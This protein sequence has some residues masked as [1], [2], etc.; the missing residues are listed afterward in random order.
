MTPRTLLLILF[1]VFS[2]TTS[3]AKKEP[4][5]ESAIPASARRVEV[6]VFLMNIYDL[7]PASNSFYADFYLWARWQGED[8][9]PLR[10]LSFSNLVEKGSYSITPA[11]GEPAVSEDGVRYMNWRVE[12]RFFNSFKVDQFP[13][14]RQT[15]ALQLENDE[16]TLDQ[17]VYVPMPAESGLSDE[18][19][20]TGWNVDR[21]ETAMTSN[22]YNTTFGLGA[23]D[24][25]AYSNTSFAVVISRPFNFFVWKLAFPLLIVLISSVAFVFFTVDDFGSRF[26]LPVYALLTAIFLQMA[27]TS[28]IPETGY[29]VLMD[30]I[31]VAAYGLI[32]LNMAQIIWTSWMCAKEKLDVARLTRIDRSLAAGSFAAFVGYGAWLVTAA[33]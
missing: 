26:Y 23:G 1:C 20:L 4:L 21:F 11:L 12:G 27:Y 15:L 13:L 8:F 25:E 32:I 10:G 9:D 33:Y 6:G 17:L 2:L 19:E 18:I 22:V 30:R 5:P 7:S 31:Y 24:Q 29:L 3:W 14:D 28:I 16:F